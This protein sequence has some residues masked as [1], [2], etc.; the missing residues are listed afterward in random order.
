MNI[1]ELLAVAQDGAET[2]F[3]EEG[4]VLPIAL[5]YGPCHGDKCGDPADHANHESIGLLPAPPGTM[6]TPERKHEWAEV[7]REI[8]RRMK[9]TV[10]VLINES[11]H[12]AIKSPADMRIAPS[13]NPRRKEVVTIYIESKD[14]HEM[15]QSFIARESS[16]KGALGPWER[17]PAPNTLE[18]GLIGFLTQEGAP[19]A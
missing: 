11:W 8:A 12:V 3:A 13:E 2:C 5:L 19:R 4:R 7:I 10:V 18:G 16:G 17:I 6:E 9:C 15:Y 1:E 14:R